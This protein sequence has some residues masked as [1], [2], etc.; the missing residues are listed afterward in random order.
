MGEVIQSKWDIFILCASTFVIVGTLLLGAAQPAEPA[1]A[2][3]AD[4]SQL[5]TIN[6]SE[7]V[8]CYVY[9]HDN[10]TEM[11]CVSDPEELSGNG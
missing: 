6:A 10:G 5:T 9:E 3:G 7:N 1:S 4:A 2:E 11:S 8:T